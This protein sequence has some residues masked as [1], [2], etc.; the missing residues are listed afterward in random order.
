MAIA[1]TRAVPAS[2]DRCE[3]TY[4]TRLPIDLER[5]RAQ[6]AEY[7]RALARHGCQVMELPEAPD[8]ADSVFV[9]DIAVV[10]DECGVITRP[11]AASRR[12]EIP[13]IRAALQPYRTLHE[14]SE[15]GTLDG[16]DVV[17]LGRRV[18]VGVSTRTNHDGI[19]QLGRILD[20]FGY[21][22]VPVEV[23]GSLHLKSVVTAV[24]D[25]LIVIDAQ[26]IDPAIFGVRFIEVPIEAANVLRVQDSVLC[27]PAAAAVAPRLAAEGLTVE[28][29]DT[30][31]LAKAEGAL[32]CCSLIVETP[33]MRNP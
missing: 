21:E 9:E 30:S 24:A 26:S 18:F 29:V 1:I 4:Q 7:C 2:I 11:G 5:A 6:H 19:A 17:R 28:L 25:D 27:P 12:A 31:E 13:S 3:L 33:S 20:A 15:P 10:F 32:T 8:L 16:G 22:V 23:Q 14:V